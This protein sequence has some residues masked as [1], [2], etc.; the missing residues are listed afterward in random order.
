M[1]I[2]FVTLKWQEMRGREKEKRKEREE[3]EGG[4]EKVADYKIPDTHAGDILL[5]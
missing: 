3:V 4:K 5:Q 2:A 1:C